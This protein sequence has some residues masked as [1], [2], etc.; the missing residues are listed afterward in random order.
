M[1]PHP[2]ALIACTGSALALTC[3]CSYNT[4][5]CS[6]TACAVLHSLLWKR[7]WILMFLLNAYC[8]CAGSLR[9]ASEVWNSL[10]YLYFYIGKW[11]NCLSVFYKETK[12]N[13][14][15]AFDTSLLG[16]STLPPWFWAKALPEMVALRPYITGSPLTQW[17]LSML[18]IRLWW[19]HVMALCQ[20]DEIWSSAA[21]T[22]LNSGTTQ[23]E[24]LIVL[25]VSCC[26][27]FTVTDCHRL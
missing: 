18:N 19:Q 25:L 9:A 8:L 3:V 13:E 21:H 16:A 6:H 14:S 7:L 23:L 1:Y 4:A 17:A 26:A 27:Y 15:H 2:H 22:G 5:T 10:S 20:S 11:Y 24:I 12:P